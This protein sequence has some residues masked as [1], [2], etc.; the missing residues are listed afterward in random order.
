MGDGRS[1][2][3]TWKTDVVLC[4]DHRNFTHQLIETHIMKLPRRQFLHLAAAAV[5]LPTMPLIAR[6]QSYPGRPVRII[7]GFAAGGVTDIVARLIGQQLSTRL[8]QFLV[9]NR[10]GAG[11]NIATEAVA[12]APADGYA[13]LLAT[14]ANAINATLYEKL[15]F[16]FIRDLAPVASIVDSPLVMT[17]N[18]SFPARSVPEFIAYAK[19]N[20]GKINMA[21]AGVGSPP[22]V[23][24]ELFKMMAGVDLIHVPYRGSAPATQDL[25]AGQVQV[26]FGD[27]SSSIEFIRGGKIRPLAVSTESRL[28]ILPDMPTIGSFLTG[29]EATSWQG[30]CAPKNTSAAV[31]LKLNGE[32]NSILAD[33]KIKTHVEDL[34]LR[35]L[36]GSPADFAKLID[37][38]TEKWAKVVKFAG[39]KAD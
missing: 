26:L 2:P 20:P 35:T 32:V 34:G 9:E 1:L 31:I 29:F 15:N 14:S 23:A 28:D 3:R 39:I 6:A 30:L 24:G 37:E 21:S 36:S 18:P 22:H 27:V 11:T 33:P 12:N 13:L 10:T 4:E 19:A 25:I 16:N 7:V 38:S 8:G 5:A 17:V